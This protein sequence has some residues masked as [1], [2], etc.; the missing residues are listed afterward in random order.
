[1]TQPSEEPTNLPSEDEVQA[2]EDD[3]QAEIDA[4]GDPEQ[5]WINNGAVVTIQLVT[6]E[7]VGDPV[8]AA[9]QIMLDIQ[10]H[11][12]HRRAIVVA[13]LGDGEEYIVQEGKVIDPAELQASLGTKD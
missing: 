4:G 8:E 13:D 11:G 10:M 6:Q 2:A 3:V 1:M 12:L 7:F 5:P 9:E